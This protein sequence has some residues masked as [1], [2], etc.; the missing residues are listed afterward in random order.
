M[1]LHALGFVVSVRISN[2]LDDE[3]GAVKVQIFRKWHLDVF[4]SHVSQNLKFNVLRFTI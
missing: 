3:S 2:G 1:K 4:V